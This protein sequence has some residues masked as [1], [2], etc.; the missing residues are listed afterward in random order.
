MLP[1]ALDQLLLPTPGTISCGVCVNAC[2]PG[3]L[4]TRGQGHSLQQGHPGHDLPLH[5]P[6]PSSLG[7]RIWAVQPEHG[8]KLTGSPAALHTTADLHVGMQALRLDPTSL[9]MNP[10]PASTPPAPGNSAGSTSCRQGSL[11]AGACPA[12]LFPPLHMAATQ[13]TA[14]PIRVRGRQH[15]LGKAKTLI[16]SLHQIRH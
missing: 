10:F 6:L 16:S 11:Q 2:S 8:G 1:S 4:N 12:G 14:G 15:A 9:G 5:S 13:H 7:V 3:H